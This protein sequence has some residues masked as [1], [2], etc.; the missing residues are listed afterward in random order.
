M[1]VGGGCR[2]GSVLYLSFQTADSGGS[3]ASE[4]WSLLSHGTLRDLTIM[5]W[6]AEISLLRIKWI[7]FVFFFCKNLLASHFKG[8]FLLC[9]E[10]KTYLGVLPLL[11]LKGHNVPA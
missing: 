5:L 11:F 1:G 4:D 6:E 9:L 7:L 2:V 10:E 3:P 8:V